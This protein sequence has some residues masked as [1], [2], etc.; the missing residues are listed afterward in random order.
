MSGPRYGSRYH[1]SQ[2]TILFQRG[3]QCPRPTHN[4]LSG[5]GKS[6]VY[7]GSG[8]YTPSERKWISYVDYRSL[9]RETRRDAIHMESEDQWVAFMRKRDSVHQPSGISLSG[10]PDLYRRN[11]MPQLLPYKQKAWIRRWD[12]PGY[13]VPPTNTWVHEQGERVMPS[14]PDGAYRFHNEEDFIKFKYMT[15]TPNMDFYKT[16]QRNIG[17]TPNI[18]GMRSC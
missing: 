14:I 2:G 12:G 10:Q 4:Y 11:P 7:H 9:P 6:H 1:T 3:H 18:V 13:F 15:D 17:L 16:P 5:D 8:Y